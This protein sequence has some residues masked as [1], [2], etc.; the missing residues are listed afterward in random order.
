M[1]KLQHLSGS[2]DGESFT[3]SPARYSKG[4]FIIRITMDNPDGFKGRGA[5]LA[6]AL[7]GRWVGRECGYNVS[8]SAAFN[9]AL[10]FGA[11]FDARIRFLDVDRGPLMF[12]SP[13]SRTGGYPLTRREAVALAR[14][15]AQHDQTIRQIVESRNISVD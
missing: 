1:T 13:N 9:F 15:L 14:R 12:W 2:R 6:E 3:I 8:Q 10:L 7:G 4:R 11:G 5:R